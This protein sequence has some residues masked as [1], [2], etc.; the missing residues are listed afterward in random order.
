MW[1]C[2]QR[3]DMK[4]KKALGRPYFYWIYLSNGV[5]GLEYKED[6]IIWGSLWKFLLETVRKKSLGRVGCLVINPRV[7]ICPPPHFHSLL[8]VTMKNWA[9][10]PS[11]RLSFCMAFSVLR[12]L[13][14]TG[15]KW[16]LGR[17]AAPFTALPHVGDEPTGR[18]QHLILFSDVPGTNAKGSS[19]QIA[20]QAPMN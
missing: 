6:I 10:S 11:P 12:G 19:K 7:L 17:T 15:E 9:G 16:V 20:L 18:T 14:A 1:V 8:A 3:A 2:I 13:P 5:R 4:T